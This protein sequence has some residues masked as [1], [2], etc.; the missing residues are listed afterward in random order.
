VRSPRC[1]PGR[2]T[3]ENISGRSNSSPRAP[4]LP[5]VGDT[6]RDYRLV[7]HLGR[8]GMGTVFKAVHVKLDKVVALKVLAGRRWNDPE[9][10][11]RFEREMKVVGRLDH[12][13]IV[14]ASDAGDADGVPFLVMEFLDGETLSTLVQRGGPLP[15]FRACGLIR[16]AAAGLHHAHQ[17]G[18][19][20]R[21]VKPSN[22]MLTR[23][24]EVKVLDLGLALSLV[25]AAETDTVLGCATGSG[26]WSNSGS[27]RT[28]PNHTVGTID[29]MAPEQKLDAHV[30]DARA[31][32]YGLGCTL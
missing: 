1:Q 10:V 30:V 16:R 19:V 32:V 20:H 9:A 26:S 8:G 25:S 29:Y 21:D 2:P 7:E 12:P 18:V 15:L 22:L 5:D 31:D 13:N 23:A 4:R 14:K 17:A 28:S 27:D 3:T 11:V 24:S 6:L